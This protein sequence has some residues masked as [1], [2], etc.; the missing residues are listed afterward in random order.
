MNEEHN[1]FRWT[2]E[3][4]GQTGRRRRRSRKSATARRT[5]FAGKNVD[6]P[7]ARERSRKVSIK[8]QCRAPR[9]FSK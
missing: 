7:D 2:E 5:E 6:V 4:E 9:S 1:R 8:G 3:V